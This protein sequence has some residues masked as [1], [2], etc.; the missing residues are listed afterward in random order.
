[1][2]TS[3]KPEYQFWGA[4]A[5]MSEL[6]GALA[7]A[8]LPKLPKITGAM[9]KAKWGIRKQIEGTRGLKFRKILDPEGDSGAFL[10]TIYE[11]PE[12]CKRFVE[13]LKAEG[14]R[15]E[16]SSNPC[17]TMEEWGLHWYFNNLSLVNKR[18]ISPSGWPW[19]LAE[20]GFAKDYDYKRG[21]L[22]VCSDLASRSGLLM[23]GSS[24]TDEDVKDVV[25]AYRKVA[26][27]LL[28]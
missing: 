18:S 4:G 26:H 15:G 19:T 16:G 12:I 5:R 22:P 17:I 23:I 8:Q 3:E 9:R 27:H 10:I 21:G 7:L 13:A 2:Q 20:N 6:T 28:K 1:M 14:L 25:A 24:M 11:N